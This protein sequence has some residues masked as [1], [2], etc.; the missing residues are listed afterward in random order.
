MFKKINEPI[1]KKM[2]PAW[3]KT[4]DQHVRTSYGYL[5]GWFSVALNLI[6]AVLKTI[7]G[8]WINS[9]SLLADAFHTFSDVV[10]SIAVICGFKI[11]EKPQDAEHPFGHGRAEYI[12]TFIVSAFLIL[13]G[14][15]FL[16]QSIGELLNPEPVDYKITVF[17]V[18]IFSAI[19]KEWLF[20]F[21][22]FLGLRINS[23]S[24]IADGWHHRSDAI[25]SLLLAVALF[26][27]QFNFHEIDAILGII[28]SFLIIYTGIDLIR[29]CSSEILGKAPTEEFVREV[30]ELVLD[31]DGVINIHDIQVHQYGQKK[32]VNVHIE[33]EPELNVRQSHYIADFV[34]GILNKQLKVSSLVHTD[35]YQES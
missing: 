7:C 15:E 12:T 26:M 30:R 8:L 13:V 6:L 10:T 35:P 25:A 17:I 32:Y 20:S 11:S 23:Q 24:L 27:T 1:L 3:E 4:S 21:A 2:I 33:V 31:V 29:D 16:K 18:L 5:E 9:I 28:V 34:E 14:A 22:Q 19:A